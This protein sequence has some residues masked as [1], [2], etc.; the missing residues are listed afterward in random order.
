M[1]LILVQAL[2]AFAQS[3][4]PDRMPAYPLFGFVGGLKDQSITISGD[5][6]ANPEEISHYQFLYSSPN[7]ALE[8]VRQARDA[9][10]YKTIVPVYMGGYTTN[11]GGATEVEQNYIDAV[12]MTDV[13]TLAASVDASATQ[14]KVALPKQGELPIVASTAENA[15][16]KNF[17]EYV[18]WVQIDQERMKVTALDKTSGAL[19]VERGFKSSPAAHE[20]NAVVLTPVY[21]GKKTDTQA[22][23]HTNSWPGARDYLRY[24]LNPA[25]DAMQQYKANVIIDLMKKGF[26]GAWLDTYQVGT[27]NLCNA[28]GEPIQRYWNF[29]TNSRYTGQTQE[30]AMEAM[31]RSIREK[32]KSAVGREPV[33]Y[34]NSCTGTYRTGAKLLFNSPERTGLLDGYCFED[35]YIHPSFE[36]SGVKKFS[37]AF[38]P[39]T[40]NRWATTVTDQAD[41]ARSHLNALCMVGPAGYVANYIVPDLT[42][43]EALMRY[44]YCSFLL[45]VTPEK[46]TTFG[47]PFVF[48]QKDQKARILPAPAIVYY[49]IG[50]PV[51]DKPLEQMQMPGTTCYARKFSNGMVIVNAGTVTAATAPTSKGNAKTQAKAKEKSAM[52]TIPEGYVA[53]DGKPL[54]TQVE[55]AVGDA[56]LLLNK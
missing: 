27:Y 22:V 37:A 52:V 13:S 11:A 35:S 1:V 24:A 23:R 32:V 2:G 19:T 31:L 51:E 43:Y 20:A 28:V 15:D 48:Q 3:S 50:D 46:T 14:I 47:L 44:S 16:P 7:Q 17:K 39:I 56:L 5:K 36:V 29:E 38:T 9:N 40:G 4:A 55:L 41:A 12:A 33:L 21:L 26:D 54:G 25:A 6:I 10:H 53:P 34:A 8:A 30:K 18:F 42:N 49:P 45:T